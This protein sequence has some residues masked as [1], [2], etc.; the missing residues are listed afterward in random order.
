LDYEKIVRAPGLSPLRHFLDV[1]V[2]GLMAWYWRDKYRPA[3]L[4][5]YLLSLLQIVL[6]REFGL[7]LLGAL[8]AVEAL[9]VCEEGPRRR[10]FEVICGGVA[11]LVASGMLVTL[12]S[13][14]NYMSQYYEAGFT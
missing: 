7:V 1:P 14:S 9:Q 5:A 3:L 8:L 11:L 4:G 6:N 12:R 13:I 2:I 10:Q